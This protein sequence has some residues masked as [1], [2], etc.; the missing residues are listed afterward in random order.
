MMNKKRQNGKR[1]RITKER[2]F[3]DGKLESDS[4][5]YFEEWGFELE[6]LQK[7]YIDEDKDVILNENNEVMF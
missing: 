6:D 4:R 1:E 3:K 5:V 7:C 2:L